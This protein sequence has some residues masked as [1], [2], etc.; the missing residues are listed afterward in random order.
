MKIQLAFLATAT[1]L[2]NGCYYSHPAKVGQ[3]APFNMTTA[4]AGMAGAGGGAAVG[5]AINRKIGA[6]VG[7]AAGAAIA[8]GATYIIQDRHQRE[9]SE[10][11]DEGKRKGRAQVFDEW[12]SEN[13]VLNDPGEKT[14]KKAPKTRQIQLPAGDY[15]SV[16]YHRR[17][18]PYIVKP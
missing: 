11:Y 12:W 17:T 9:L 14:D 5:N 7:A 4:V 2:L 13:A 16:P 18:Y 3:T 6:P 1:L 10:A 8:G 15:E